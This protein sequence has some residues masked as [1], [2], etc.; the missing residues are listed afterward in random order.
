MFYYTKSYTVNSA[1]VDL[2][3]SLYLV[4]Y[5][6]GSGLVPKPGPVQCTVYNSADGLFTTLGTAQFSSGL[7]T[8]PGPV[9][10]NRWTSIKTRPCTG[11]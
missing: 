9:K 1:G 4:L 3:K 5:S 2:D 7:I 8:I 6:I 11:L 10:Y